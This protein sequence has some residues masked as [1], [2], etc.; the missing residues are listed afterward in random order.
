M[1]NAKVK[2]VKGRVKRSVAS[3]VGTLKSIQ[4]S[5]SNV[6]GVV[7]TNPTTTSNRCR[8][9]SFSSSKVVTGV[10]GMYNIMKVLLK[11]LGRDLRSNI[12]FLFFMYKNEEFCIK[13]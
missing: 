3:H 1:A 2:R 11:R 7:I 5:E 6:I 8:N 13:I 4:E 12:L 10:P 9:E